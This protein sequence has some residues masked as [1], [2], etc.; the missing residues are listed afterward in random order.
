MRDNNYS[1]DDIVTSSQDDHGHSAHLRVHV[2]KY[3]ASMLEFLTHSPWWPEYRSSQDVLRDA[4]Y[5]RLHWVDQQHGRE[6]FPHVQEALARERL[7]ARLRADEADAAHREE[8]LADIERSL[9]RNLAE[10]DVEAARKTIE[11]AEGLMADLPQP[12]ASRFSASVREWRTQ[13]D[14]SQ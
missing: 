14:G 9:S 3:W 2:P 12:F 4:I 11:E 7:L 6:Q 8:M 13:V 5:H 1:P 10:G